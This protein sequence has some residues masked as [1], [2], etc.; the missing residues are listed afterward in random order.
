MFCVYNHTEKV[1]QIQT[2][3]HYDEDWKY[4]HRHTNVTLY[5]LLAVQL[6]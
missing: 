5:G 6:H 3:V 4:W 1:L 2:I